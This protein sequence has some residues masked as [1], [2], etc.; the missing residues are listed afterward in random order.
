MPRVVTPELHTEI[1]SP[2]RAGEEGSGSA[3]PV[4]VR[5]VLTSH[6]DLRQLTMGA[7][8]GTTESGPGGFVFHNPI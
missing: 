1:E 5:P 3:R 8:P 7:T 6:G 4:W 2:P